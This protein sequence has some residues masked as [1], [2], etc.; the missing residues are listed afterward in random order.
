MLR[1]KAIIACLQ[2]TSGEDK[3]ALAA[4]KTY[5]GGRTIAIDRTNGGRI[6]T[7]KRAAVNGWKRNTIPQAN[8]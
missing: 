6:D 2:S 8:A 3:L 1:I 4:S 7:G 5:V